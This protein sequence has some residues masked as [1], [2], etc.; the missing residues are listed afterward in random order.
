MPQ[1]S[2]TDRFVAGAKS[3]EVQTD[4]F[5]DNSKTRGLCLR[6]TKAGRKSW[7][8]IFTSPKDGKRAR[9]TLGGYPSTSLARAR[10]LVIEAH[11]HLEGGRDPRDVAAAQSASAMTVAGMIE[12]FLQKHAK[13]SLR[14]ADE[15]ERRL[16]KNVTPIIGSMKLADLHRR[17]MN[18]VVDPVLKRNRRVEASRVFEDLRS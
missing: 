18:R 14:S 17:D 7:C 12:S 10:A 13:P 1:V 5:D 11:G 16:A 6:V 4:Y 3:S 15:I 2:L 9:M 8:L